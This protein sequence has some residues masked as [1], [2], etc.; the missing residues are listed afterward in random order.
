MFPAFPLQMPANREAGLAATYHYGVDMLAHYP[1]PYR[2]ES[3]EFPLIAPST[4]SVPAPAGR[5]TPPPR[6][7][8]RAGRW[9]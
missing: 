4:N 3:A 9:N 2:S 5:F 8:G 7:A 6:A 1:S